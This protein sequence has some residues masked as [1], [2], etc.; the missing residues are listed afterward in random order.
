MSEH[1]TGENV[2]RLLGIEDDET[3]PVQRCKP[4]GTGNHGQIGPSDEPPQEGIRLCAYDPVPYLPIG[5]DNPCLV[6]Y[7]GQVTRCPNRGSGF[8]APGSLQ[9]KVYSAVL[10]DAAVADV[11]QVRLLEE[12][13]YNPPEWN[14]AA[15]DRDIAWA[16]FRGVV[17]ESQRQPD[18][19][20]GRVIV[21]FFQN[22]SHNRDRLAA[23]NVVVRRLDPDC[24]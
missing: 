19:T 5:T 21:A 11:V 6:E 1:R 18:G 17:Y 20:V 7:R 2:T 10:P 24:V 23:V 12:S 22:W 4:E 13:F 8:A 9:T 14:E 3:I 15:V 16:A